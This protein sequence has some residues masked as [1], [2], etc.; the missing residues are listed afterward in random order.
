[1]AWTYHSTSTSEPDAHGWHSLF[2]PIFAYCNHTSSRQPFT[3][4]YDTVTARQTFDVS[5]VAR[6]VVGGLYAKMLL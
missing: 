5:F 3:D 1:M 6:P 2:D 4:L